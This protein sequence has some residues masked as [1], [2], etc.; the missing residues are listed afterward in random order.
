MASCVAC[1]VAAVAGWKTPSAVP[2]MVPAH[3][4]DPS[5]GFWGAW[6]IAGRV[7]YVDLV[8]DLDNHLALSSQPNAVN[9]GRQTTYT[10][11]LNWYPNTYMRFM[12]NYIHTDFDKANTS[13]TSVLYG[14]NIGAN[15]DAIA[16]RT[17]VA[18]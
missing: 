6:E 8:N 5:Q 2:A 7:S 3:A 16:L 13:S 1:D 17:Q 9:G 14:T 18:W 4:F 10:A 12:L 11:G 15:I